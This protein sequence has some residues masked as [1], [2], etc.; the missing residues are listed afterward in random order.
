MS[1]INL[2]TGRKQNKLS[3]QR[4]SRVSKTLSLFFA[5]LF[6]VSSLIIVFLIV[7]N[8][9]S[10]SSLK[11]KESQLESEIKSLSDIEAKYYFIKDRASKGSSILESRNSLKRLDDIKSFLGIVGSGQLEKAEA[12]DKSVSFSFTTVNYEEIYNLVNAIRQNQTYSKVVL[13]S[14]SFSPDRGYTVD[15]SLDI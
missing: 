6:F 15:I 13:K 7:Y 2:L 9:S 8:Q 4:V 11:E 14:L 12:S 5:L 3:F 1:D 10:I